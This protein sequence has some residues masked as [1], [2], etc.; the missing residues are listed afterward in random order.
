MKLEELQSE[1]EKDLPLKLTALQSEAADNAVLYGKW[2]RYLSD[3]KKIMIKNE[4]A[5]KIASRDSLFYHTGR[6][7]DICLDEFSATELRIVI[8]AKDEVL[9][10]DAMVKLTD[11]KIEFCKGALEAIKQRGFN[12]KAIV[13]SRKHESGG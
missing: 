7:D 9:D 1:L 2:L 8:P 13:E 4:R 11:M 12:I 6:G 10:A 5:L 3:F